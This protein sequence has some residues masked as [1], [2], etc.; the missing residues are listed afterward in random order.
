MPPKLIGRSDRR[1]F[2]LQ[3][4]VVAS[5]VPLHPEPGPPIPI[6]K[7]RV[8]LGRHS[9][10]DILV[11]ADGVSRRHASLSGTPDG[12]FVEDLHSVNGT[13]I[14]DIA[15]KRGR[16]RDGDF[17]RLGTAIFKFLALPNLP[18]PRPPDRTW[19]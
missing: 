8:L 17:L 14:N 16:L 7:T 15:I 19:N 10:C 4:R 13:F 12:W 3:C 6:Y 18:R 11:N 9:G 5:L 2:A 1:E